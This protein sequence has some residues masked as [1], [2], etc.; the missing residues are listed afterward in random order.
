MMKQIAGTQE[1]AVAVP[2]RAT[3]W[4][5]RT[6]RTKDRAPGVM[7]RAASPDCAIF[8][9]GYELEPMP[10]PTAATIT[11]G[12][13]KNFEPERVEKIY[14][15]INALAKEFKV[16]KSEISTIQEDRKERF[17][18]GMLAGGNVPPKKKA[19]DDE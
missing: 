5:V 3:G 7:S 15:G 13:Q 12:L 8:Y 11:I 18:S 6:S 10:A 14:D 16:E 1:E 9:G 19:N 2:G 17:D 4:E